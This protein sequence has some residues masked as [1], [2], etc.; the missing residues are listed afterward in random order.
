MKRI[1]QTFTERQKYDFGTGLDI[2]ETNVRF[3]TFS[4]D[5]GETIDSRIFDFEKPPLGL[6]ELQ[7]RNNVYVTADAK[8]MIQPFYNKMVQSYFTKDSGY[9]HAVKTGL[10]I[11]GQIYIPFADSKVSDCAVRVSYNPEIGVKSNV[12]FTDTVVAADEITEGTISFA[13][14]FN[15]V[16]PSISV[17]QLSD[18]AIEVQLVDGAGQKIEKAGVKIY[19]KTDGGFLVFSE[20][21]TDAAGVAMFRFMP[22]GLEAGDVASVEF[23][24]KWV[25]NLGNIKVV[26]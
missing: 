24:F 12:P 3:Y 20:S 19:G 15:Q 5:T 4:K 17:T 26:A 8:G 14:F 10:S 25:S 21:V 6:K 22:L 9:K 2:Q 23:G 13:D 16:S 7:A 1:G 18:N 11:I